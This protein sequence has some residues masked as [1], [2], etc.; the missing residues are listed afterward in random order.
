MGP[1][2]ILVIGYGQ[3]AQFTGAALDELRRLIDH[4]V[5]RLVDL[6]FVHK[7]DDGSIEKIELTDTDELAKLGAVAG[8][9]IGFGAAGEEGAEVGAVAGAVGAVDEGSVFDEEQVWYIADAIPAGMSAGIA[10]LEHRWAIPLRE[11]VTAAG[12]VALA[13]E[14]LHPEDLVAL[15]L[16]AAAAGE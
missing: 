12:G 10:V 13:D 14:W 16:E 2:Q 1:V 6:L 9:L 8:A 7:N 4:D 5:V 11:A 15:G 3:D